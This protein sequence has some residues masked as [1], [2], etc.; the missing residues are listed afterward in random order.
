MLANALRRG[1]NMSTS[2]A[3]ETPIEKLNTALAEM[4]AR[5]YCE[6]TPLS[7][8]CILSV[9]HYY[10]PQP[11]TTVIVE[12]HDDGGFGVYAPVEKTYS[13]NAAIAALKAL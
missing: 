6:S 13:F 5:C 4:G 2:A 9:K 7:H 8:G 10:I 3:V 1:S 11:K 12:V